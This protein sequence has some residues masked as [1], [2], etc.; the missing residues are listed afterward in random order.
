ML[1][2]GLKR[3]TLAD[4]LLQ[5]ALARHR[6]LVQLPDTLRRRAGLNGCKEALDRGIRRLRQHHDGSH[7]SEKVRRF[8]R[9]PRHQVNSYDG[10]SSLGM[11]RI[12][13]TPLRTSFPR[14]PSRRPVQVTN[15]ASPDPGE[16]GYPLARRQ[17]RCGSRGSPV[18]EKKKCAKHHAKPRFLDAPTVL[19]TGLKAVPNGPSGGLKN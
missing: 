18:F 17:E 5:T 9:M 7:D 3:P 6:R 8:R 4:F 2:T 19:N 15:R 1:N 14:F 16:G 10:A 12:S 11:F 13:A